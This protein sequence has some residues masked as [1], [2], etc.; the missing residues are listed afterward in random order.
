ME[1]YQYQ[2]CPPGGKRQPLSH[3]T[4]CYDCG[5]GSCYYWMKCPNIRECK[6]KLEVLKFA[7]DKM[8]ELRETITK[9]ALGMRAALDQ[10]DGK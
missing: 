10:W 8:T 6:M 7:N 4:C 3:K 1:C 2:S 9:I 5:K